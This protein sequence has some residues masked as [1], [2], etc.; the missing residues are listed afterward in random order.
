M[1]EPNRRRWTFTHYGSDGFRSISLE[2]DLQTAKLLVDDGRCRE[3]LELLDNSDFMQV[4]RV[5]ESP[6]MLESFDDADQKYY[7]V[8]CHTRASI[9]TRMGKDAEAAEWYQ[10]AINARP[11]DA[12]PWSDKAGCHY[13]LG[14]YE[15]AIECARSA[16]KASDRDELAWQWW[17]EALRAIG[18]DVQALDVLDRGLKVI[19]N[20]GRL[21]TDKASLI[22]G[23]GC[24]QEAVELTEIVLRNNPNNAAVWFNQGVY[25][26]MLGNYKKALEAFR[27]AIELA[28][29][30]GFYWQQFGITLAVLGQPEAEEA[31]KEALRLL[32]GDE[33][34]TMVLSA[35]YGARGEPKKSLP[36]IERALLV[37]PA[38][39]EL[40]NLKEEMLRQIYNS[41][42]SKLHRS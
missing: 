23:K 28:P 31:L 38:S 14:Q 12:E 33:A 42:G 4:I 8:F 2:K 41:V 22:A 25:L 21:L 24:F 18:D 19:K 7:A 15:L 39:K 29:A 30:E 17:A 32:P 34:A 27:H 26:C 16:T 10:R 9:L 37:N 6:G 3:G 40:L 11:N 5:C 13:R 36:Y 20:S 1:A 35:F